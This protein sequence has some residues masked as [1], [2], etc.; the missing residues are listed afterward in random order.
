MNKKFYNVDY[1]MHI[2]YDLVKIF[3][4]YLCEYKVYEHKL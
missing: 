2:C 4:A 1:R 3:N